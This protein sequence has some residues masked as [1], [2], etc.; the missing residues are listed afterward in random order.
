M[1]AANADGVSVRYAPLK[2]RGDIFT[3]YSSAHNASR[4]LFL[5][6]TDII[7][8]FARFIL[9]SASHGFIQGCKIEF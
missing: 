3:E 4:I 2:D 1:A 5:G 6:R 7:Y 8:I 9:V